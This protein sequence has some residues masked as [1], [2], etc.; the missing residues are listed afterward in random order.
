MNKSRYENKTYVGSGGMASVYK[1]F[2]VTLQ[3][4]VAIKVMADQLRN[5][6]SVR[7]LFTSEARKMASINHQNVVHV[8]DVSDDDDVPTIYMEYMRGG[9]L[10]SLMGSGPMA[11]EEV[12][13]IMRHV[14][15][16][17]GAIHEQGLVHRD[18]KPENILEDSG[19]YKITDFGVAMSGDEDALPFVTSKYAAPEVLIE[20][21]KIGP[22]S[23]IYSLGN[24]D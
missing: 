6:E 13:K 20:P 15:L 3:R 19:T 9:N 12:L 7:D 22:S 24:G 21:E 8:Y 14:I 1:A 23:D 11:G 18:V 5:N 10:A 2:D 17:L 16:G 4:D